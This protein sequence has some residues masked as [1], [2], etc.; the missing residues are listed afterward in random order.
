[1]SKLIVANWKMNP[2]TFAKAEKLVKASAAG[3]RDGVKVVLCPPFVY[4]T[5]ISQLLKA[6]S[7]KLK[8]SLGAQDVF[9]EDKGAYTG[10]ISPAM[11]K[12]SGVKYVIVGH[13]ERR[14]LGETDEMV[15]K[16]LKAAL[17]SGLKPILCVGEGRDV[18]RR[19]IAAAKNFVK[20]QLRND[21]AGVKRVK[22]KNLIVAYEPVWAIST[23]KGG[24]VDAP[25]DAAEMIQ[26]IKSLLHTTYHIP[27]TNV[28]Y[29][30]SVTS[31]S[32]ASFLGRPEIDGVLVGGASIKTNWLST[33]LYFH[34][35][36][37]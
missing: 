8:I 28:L 13:S 21:L 1:M 2:N 27:H 14:R 23:E 19:G 9:W 22:S 34:T 37:A 12:N 31:A 17:K 11:L 32:S 4:L 6:E 20:R 35:Q 25:E 33:F 5:G 29:G 16:K 24:H 15:N 30:G 10:E 36:R 3:L 26:F 18:R 7:Y